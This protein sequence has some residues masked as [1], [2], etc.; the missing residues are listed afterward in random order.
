MLIS[1]LQCW[2]L[3]SADLNMRTSKDTH[4]HASSQDSPKSVL[5]KLLLNKK[6]NESKRRLDM[7][8]K[9]Q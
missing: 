8:N 1:Q 6:E 7:G 4:S 5:E 9:S 3:K 2:L